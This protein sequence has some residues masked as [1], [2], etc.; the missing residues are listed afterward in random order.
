MD[1]GSFLGLY[2]TYTRH[3]ILPGSN[4]SQSQKKNIKIGVCTDVNLISNTTVERSRDK[5]PRLYSNIHGFYLFY[6]I[7]YTKYKK[8]TTSLNGMSRISLPIG[9]LSCTEIQHT[10]YNIPSNIPKDFILFYILFSNSCIQ[11]KRDIPEIRESRAKESGSSLYCGKRKTKD[12]KSQKNTAHVR[13]DQGVNRP[14]SNVKTPEAAMGV[15]LWPSHRLRQFL[16]YP[17]PY[18]AT[19]HP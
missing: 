3:Q 18:L 11:L 7:F 12:I 17:L 2:I 13:S 8:S 16:C 6:F 14:I 5:L 19:P 10:T 1:G 4:L 15:S 9:T